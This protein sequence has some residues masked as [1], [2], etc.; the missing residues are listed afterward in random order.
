M[1]V[2]PDRPD[3]RPEEPTPPPPPPGGTDFPPPPPPPGYA[4]APAGQRTPGKA[5]ASLVLGIVGLFI[6]P[7]VCSVLAIVFG[8]QARQEIDADPALGGR[9]MATAGFVLGIV[10]LAI[11]SLFIL[12]TLAWS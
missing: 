8:H 10:G 7:I 11:A 1:N 2:P 4:A 3:Q 12:L 9:G 5:T 6:C